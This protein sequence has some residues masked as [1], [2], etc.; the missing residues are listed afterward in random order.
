MLEFR[1]FANPFDY[2]D[3]FVLPI[4]LVAAWFYFPYC[5]TGPNLCICRI[6]LHRTCPGCGLTR[7]VCFLVHGHLRQ[8]MTFNKLSVVVLSLMILNFMRSLRTAFP[9]PL[10]SLFS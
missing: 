3:L 2:P 4:V 8:A 6:L 5:Q 1:R 10:H 7:G 9:K